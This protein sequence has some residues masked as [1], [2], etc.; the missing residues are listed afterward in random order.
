MRRE[1][2]RIEKSVELS[3]GGGGGIFFWG[4]IFKSLWFNF[5]KKNLPWK[6]FF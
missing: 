3:L 6:S 2:I 4:K 1:E 5:K